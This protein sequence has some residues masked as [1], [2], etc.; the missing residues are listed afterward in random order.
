[1]K[2]VQCLHR[3]P[4]SNLGCLPAPLPPPLGH[5]LEQFRSAVCQVC[6]RLSKV[7][8]DQPQKGGWSLHPAPYMGLGA[9]PGI[10]EQILD[11]LLNPKN[12][13]QC[14]GEAPAPPL[15]GLHRPQRDL[16]I[17]L[18][19]QL[20]EWESPKTSP[21][22][23]FDKGLRLQPPLWGWSGISVASERF[24]G[25]PLEPKKKSWVP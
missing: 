24:P 1:M 9:S 13:V 11:A 18:R 21:G 6:P 5:Q 7:C 4:R 25:I 3:H 12:W 17:R 20:R 15:G 23:W 10:Q 8:P 14:R 19:H 2:G 16:T 22:A